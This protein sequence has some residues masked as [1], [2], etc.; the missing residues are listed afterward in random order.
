MSER[1]VVVTGATAGVGRATVRALA[2]R[3]DRVA[4]IAR[5][6]E[7]LDATLAEVEEAGAKGLA[8]PL[9]VADA[10]AVDAAAQRIEDELGPI[11]VWV[12][13]AMTAVMAPVT[14]TP[15][16]E[17]RRVTE[18][19]YLGF[20]HGTLAAL[21]HMGR[22]DRGVIVQV[23]SALAYRAIPLQAT[24]CG[25]KHAMKGFTESLRT[26]LLHE[27]SGVSV[28]MVH[29]PGLN[30]PQFRWVRSRMSGHPRPVAP[31]YHPD[32]AARAILWAAEHP[33]RRQLVVGYPTAALVYGSTL[34]GGLLDRYLARTS[35]EAQQAD[36]SLPPSTEDYL[37][38]PVATDHGAEGPFGDEA[39]A[40]S[41]QLELATHL[42]TTAAGAALGLG[43]LGAG[44][45]AL[46]RRRSC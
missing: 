8:L 31:V 20:V 15:A 17:F 21:R 38:E 4:L 18:V 7:K 36:A 45:R 27:H 1:V 40:R 23:G 19:V 37:Y 33:Q 12:N 6:Q 25:A 43:M 44:V 46:A 30:T 35:V 34:V 32:V 39:H 3:G 28:T 10:T 41:L 11:D 24:Y 29:L 5:G 9:D 26:E 42:G 14:E 13:N 2:R 16:E 22:R